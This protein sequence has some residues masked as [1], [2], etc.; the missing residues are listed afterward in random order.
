MAKDLFYLASYK[1]VGKLFD[2]ILT[3]KA[4]EAFTTVFLTDTIGLKSTADRQLISMLKKLGFLEA[5]GNPTETYGLLKN[6]DTRGAAIADGLRKAYAPLFE[7]NEKA[8]ELTPEQLKGLIAQ[9]TGGEKNIVQQIAYTFNAIAKN[10]DFSKRSV[11]AAGKKPDEGKDKEPSVPPPVPSGL[12]S[13]FHFNIQVHLPANG[14]EE[15][16]L[17]IFNAP[18]RTFS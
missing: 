3:A 10:A 12:R 4:P 5:G 17:N 9:V 7:A 6:K 8:N 2:T 15:T 1:N 13:D 16:Y 14:T 11:A 18:R